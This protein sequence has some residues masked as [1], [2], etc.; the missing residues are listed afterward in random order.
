MPIDLVTPQFPVVDSAMVDMALKAAGMGFWEWDFEA[1]LGKWCLQHHTMV[2]LRREDYTGWYTDFFQYVHPDDRAL[3]E[4]RIALAVAS[5]KLY[6][7]DYRAVWPDGTVRWLSAK[8]RAELSADGEPRRMRGVVRDVTDERRAANLLRENEC[9]QREFVANVSHE[10]RTP[11]AAIKGFA[12]T[13]RLGGLDDEKNRIRFIKIIEFHAERLSALIENLLQL[14]SIDSGTIKVQQEPVGLSAVIVDYLGSIEAL[15]RRRGISI[16]VQIGPA[17]TALADKQM[18]LQV[19]ENL[20]GNA[21]KYNRP[22]G[23][24]AARA[25]VKGGKVILSVQDSGVGISEEDLPRIFDRFFRVQKSA[26]SGSG[27]GLHIAQRL[28]EAQGGRIWAESSLGRG[29]TF[30]VQ[31]PAAPVNKKLP[32]THSRVMA[33]DPG[34]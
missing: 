29:S 1:E 20:F 12:E 30:F 2:G 19:L 26:S 18:L 34:R 24:I 15:T 9:A 5:G 8:G 13:L 22:G 28:V 25:A 32:E 6:E 21:I 16:S 11:V 7:S 33:S 14:S 27:L 17:V 23:A 4:S 31:L 3:L 10:F